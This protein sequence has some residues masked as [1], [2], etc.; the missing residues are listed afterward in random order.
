M[1]QMP[2]LVCFFGMN[3]RPNGHCLK[4]GNRHEWHVHCR[5]KNLPSLSNRKDTLQI[6]WCFDDSPYSANNAIMC[7]NSDKEELY[8]KVILDNAMSPGN[9]GAGRLSPSSW[10][11]Y[12]RRTFSTVLNAYSNVPTHRSIP[13][14]LKEEGLRS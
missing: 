1:C 2:M 3:F 13:R 11:K 9:C 8:G 7:Y 10:A 14:V 6:T 12:T 5:G 4:G